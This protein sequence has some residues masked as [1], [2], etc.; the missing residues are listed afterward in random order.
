[1]GE[2]VDYLH[3]PF[4]ST[5]HSVVQGCTRREF[6]LLWSG[7]MQEGATHLL[8]RDIDKGEKLNLPK[9]SG[10]QYFIAAVQNKAVRQ[11]H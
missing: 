3:T 9:S 4:N 5:I 11:L 6:S 8:H 2:H 1:M 10:N 7:G